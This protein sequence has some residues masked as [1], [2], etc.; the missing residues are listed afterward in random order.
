MKW[1]EQLI[2][3]VGSLVT[4]AMSLWIALKKTSAQKEIN[5]KSIQHEHTETIFVGYSKIVEDLRDEV[6]RLN[7]IIFDL[8]K[9]QEECERRNEE[10]AKVVNELKHRVAYLE[11]GKK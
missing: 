10:L 4:G 7:E 9:E 2:I 1:I 11:G 5:T 3:A 6:T 8:R